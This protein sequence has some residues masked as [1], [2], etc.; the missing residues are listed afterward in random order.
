MANRLRAMG[1]PAYRNGFRVTLQPQT[2]E[3]PLRWRRSRRIFVNS[4]SDLFHE[5][6]PMEYIQRVFSIIPRAWWHQFQ[7]LT[8]RSGRLTELAETLDWPPNLWM[9]VS[10]ERDDY[11]FRIDGLRRVPAAVRFLSLEPLLGPLP[12]LNLS[13][14]AW[15]I[16]GGESG[17]HCR[18]MDEAWVR[19]LRDQCA[20]A[21]V[22]FF[23]KQWGGTRK[24]KA[25]RI[26]D[27]RF[28]DAA[29]AAYPIPATS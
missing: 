18:P 5:D 2:L 6:V 14:I 27:G 19:D 15:L 26:L 22:P 13:G 8:K 12:E 29:P 25:G 4:M 21:N 23:F 16:V 20:A 1:A 10:V 9:G 3:V 24:K 28:H 7:V 11:R 17:P